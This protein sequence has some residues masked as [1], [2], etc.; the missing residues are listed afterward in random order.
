M[1]EKNIITKND[2]KNTTKH[3]V[4]TIKK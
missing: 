4:Q 3:R 2:K 1:M